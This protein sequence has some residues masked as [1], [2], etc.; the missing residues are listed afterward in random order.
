[1]VPA[2]GHAWDNGLITKEPT[3]T[4]EGEKTYICTTCGETKLQRVPMLSHTH[5]YT[6]TVVAPTCTEQ[7]YTTH[8][9]T[10]CGDSYVADYLSAKGHTEV[11]DKAVTPTCT[12]GGFTEGK[13]CSVCGEVLVAQQVIPAVGHTYDDKYDTDCNACGEKREPATAAMPK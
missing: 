5:S 6:A 9:C 7:G 1:M 12:A 11:I 2:K 13:H 10:V 8:T 4:M 3:E